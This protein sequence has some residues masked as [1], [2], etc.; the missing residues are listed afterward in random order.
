MNHVQRK[1]LE[2]LSRK[3][4]TKAVFSLKG[5]FFSK[6]WKFPPLGNLKLLR[7]KLF[8]MRNFFPKKGGDKNKR[9]TQQFS[10]EMIQYHESF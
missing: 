4:L 1:Q 3:Y 6:L 2:L 9:M 8:V 10:V 5:E 7:K